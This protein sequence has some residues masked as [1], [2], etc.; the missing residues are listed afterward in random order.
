MPSGSLAVPD[1][2]TITPASTDW[3]GPAST[4]GG[5]LEVA[6][7]SRH[8]GKPSAFWKMHKASDAVMAPSGCR[9]LREDVRDD[10][11]A[12]IELCQA[13]RLLKYQQGIGGGDAAVLIHV[14]IDLAGRLGA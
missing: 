8:D 12:G 1:R 5:W 6:Q 13:Q 10:L 14:A 11:L 3:S 2:N 4:T 7:G 9:W